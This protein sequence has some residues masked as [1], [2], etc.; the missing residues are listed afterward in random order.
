MKIEYSIIKSV[1]SLM[2]T[3]F[4]HL[5]FDILFIK[6]STSVQ[7]IWADAMKTQIAPILMDL[8]IALATMDMKEMASIALVILIYQ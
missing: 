1:A 5:T 2:F 8:T 6:I 7:E 4:H 3:L